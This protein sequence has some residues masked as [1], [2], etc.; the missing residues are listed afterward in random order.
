M[1]ILSLIIALSLLL[2]GCSSESAPKNSAFASEDVDGKITDSN[3]EFAFDVFG[4]LNKGDL[5][6][7]VFIS[8][9]SISTALAMTYNGAEGETLEEMEE[10]LNFSGIPRN[11]VNVSYKSLLDY[12]VRDD[13]EVKTLV[14]NSIWYRQGEEIREEYLNTIEDYYKAYIKDLD[15]DK[16]EAVDTINDWIDDSTKG[17]IP[18]M[19]QPPIPRDVLMYL[20]NAVYFKGEWTTQFKE[21]D[22]RD[23]TFIQYDKTEVSVPMMWMNDTIH[24]Y[25]GDNYKSVKLPYGDGKVSMYI[26][27]P[28]EGEDIN[29]HIETFNLKQYNEIKN[30]LKETEDLNLMI[31]KFK[32]E[33]GI[34]DITKELR[35]LGMD[36]IFDERA[37]L[38]S[39][40][41][42]IYVSSVL[43][44]AVI[45]VNEQGSEAAGV[46]VV[47]VRT[48]SIREP[49]TFIA[50]RPF[51][52]F[53][54]DEESDTILFM[55]KYLKI[56]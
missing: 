11:I 9:F 23:S 39:I 49:V 29:N 27:L 19:L 43:H 48:T 22:T 3:L 54:G 4:E 32:M 26:V 30:N 20:I 25:K 16:P 45:E 18:G 24:Y 38:S 50:D 13:K 53:I 8:P 55:G 46:T 2:V 21:E 37:D 42:D 41:E 28:D 7:N 6:E 35:A 15:F 34:K 1:K 10:V 40:R 47:E 52:F 33:Y 51:F 17:M 36:T 12:L 44:Q 56:N 14:S 31:P 5:N